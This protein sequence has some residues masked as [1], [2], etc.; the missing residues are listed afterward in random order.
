MNFVPLRSETSYQYARQKTTRTS[1]TAN[2]KGKASAIG[3]WKDVLKLLNITR[4]QWHQ[5]F[6]WKIQIQNCG[7]FKFIK[8]MM[9]S[10]V[11]SYKF[12]LHTHT[13]IRT[14]I[15]AHI[16]TYIQWCTEGGGFGVFKPLPKFWRPSKIMPNSTWLW[17]LLKIAEIRK[18]THQD[19]R[20]IGSKIL[21]LPR[22][23]IILH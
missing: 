9:S 17:K 1:K 5:S 10:R 6:I 8:A 3:H 13:H 15:H 7:W 21:K 19:V 16:R 20:K 2:D 23:A 4:N 12:H 18:T 14:Y 11:D 22:F